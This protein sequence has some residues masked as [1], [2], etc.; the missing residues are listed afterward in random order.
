MLEEQKSS[1]RQNL[2]SLIELAMERD[3]CA[4]E[5]FDELHEELL[6]AREEA[7]AAEERLA[8]SESV[9]GMDLLEVQEIVYELQSAKE[10][11]DSALS[12]VDEGFKSLSAIYNEFLEFKA[13]VGH[14][15][16]QQHSIICEYEKL[17]CCMRKKVS[18]VEREKLLMDNQSVD[19]QEQIQEI[20]EFSE[21]QN[22]EN[23][24]LLTQIQTLE[25]ELSYLSSSSLAREK[26][27]LR[28][29]LEKTK[30]KLKETECKLKNAVQEKTKLEGEKAFAEREVKRLHGQ[31]TLL[32][33]DITKLDSHS[34]RRRDSV[35]DKTSK[36]FDPKRGKSPGVPYELM[37][38]DYKKLEILAF[39]M[40]TAIASLEEQLA[41]ASRER[42][43][44]LTRNENLA[45]ELEAKSERFSKSSTELN[46]LRE[47]VSG[48]RLGI[49][50]SKLNEQKMQSSIK[51]LYEE[52]EELAMQLTDSL[53]EMEEE[54]AIWSAKEKASIEAIEEK[55]KLYN[56]EC[57]SLLK[58]MSKVRNELE[59]CREECMYLRERLA[60]S[61]EEAKLEKKCSGE[62]G[63]TQL[64]I[65]QWK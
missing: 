5:K 44:A 54:K 26:E 27:S 39:E 64:Q 17:R 57:A 42:E 8:S 12:L 14:I 34:G 41:A 6:N 36:M 35:V 25:N 65:K 24:D 23:L 3:I 40:E 37:Q 28:K 32:E 30:S 38:E 63:E 58:G 61:E 7:K 53:L 56:A 52:K 16:G 2:D 60:S 29:D 47:E 4:S 49:E 18:E 46:I 62:K 45:S 15:S 9:G 51:I 59:S 43:E 11:V 13:L 33:R 22:M 31:N 48:L 20:R 50:E 21:Q 55:A 19:L 10:V 1:S